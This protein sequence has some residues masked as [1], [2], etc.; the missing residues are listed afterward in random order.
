MNSNVSTLTSGPPVGIRF[1]TITESM[2]DV[3][4]SIEGPE[5]LPAVP[6]KGYFLLKIF[7]PHI[8]SNGGVCAHALKTNLKAGLG[9]RHILL[10]IQ[11]LLS[12]LKPQL[13]QNEDPRHYLHW[14]HVISYPCAAVLCSPTTVWY[15]LGFP[16]SR[17]DAP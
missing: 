9:V 17:L 16:Y 5:D 2:T 14:G 4:V 10:P 12:H 11:C 1:F 6:P 3:R 8:S 15:T 13:A 7:H